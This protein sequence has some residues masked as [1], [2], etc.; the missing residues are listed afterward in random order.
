MF[1]YIIL[2]IPVFNL[3]IGFHSAF[4][5]PH[6]C[7]LHFCPPNCLVTLA[8]WFLQL[9]LPPATMLA[10][11]IDFKNQVSRIHICLCFLPFT[12]TR[13]F[14]C[15]VLTSH[16]LNKIML[17]QIIECELMIIKVYITGTFWRNTALRKDML[18]GG[19]RKRILEW[20]L[21]K[22]GWAAGWVLTPYQH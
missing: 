11:V 4:S 13:S 12:L 3:N 17:L 15:L 20:V 21:S 7:L 22:S 16:T 1:I 14:V 19:Q 10:T 5:R 2:L 6:S 8:L 9:F 18:G